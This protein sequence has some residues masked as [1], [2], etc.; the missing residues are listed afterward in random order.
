MTTILNEIEELKERY[1]ELK[2]EHFEKLDT[3]KIITD[4]IQSNKEII[5]DRCEK[6]IQIEKYYYQRLLSYLE[7][8]FNILLIPYK[9]FLGFFYKKL[10]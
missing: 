9:Y 6:S 7:P 8:I 5:E 1:E 4:F 3:T 10:D 2:R